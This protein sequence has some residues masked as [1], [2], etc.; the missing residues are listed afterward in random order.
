MRALIVLTLALGAAAVFAVPHAEQPKS[1]NSTSRTAYAGLRVAAGETS[2]TV[3]MNTGSR[4]WM[5]TV[6][7]DTPTTNITLNITSEPSGASILSQAVA[8]TTGVTK[9]NLQSATTPFGE[10]IWEAYQ[11]QVIQNYSSAVDILH[12]IQCIKEEDGR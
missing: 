10:P 4:G 2:G 8:T 12:V 6:Y 5:T 3:T 7:V 11:V 1:Y 9:I